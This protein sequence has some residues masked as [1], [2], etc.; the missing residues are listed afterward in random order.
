MRIGAGAD[1]AQDIIN[2][3]F[4]ADIDWASLQEK[5]LVAPYRPEIKPDPE[6]S[7]ML[8]LDNQT[9]IQTT[10]VSQD[11]SEKMPESQIQFI[12]DN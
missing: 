4:F 3:P 5:K 7:L 2:H 11:A 10:I 12:R 9:Q 6:Q 8:D 1:D